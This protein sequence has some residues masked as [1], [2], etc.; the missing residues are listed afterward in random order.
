MTGDQPDRDALARSLE[1]RD[2]VAAQVALLRRAGAT[3]AEA[4][5][6]LMTALYDLSCDRLGDVEALE[7]MRRFTDEKELELM[8]AAR[9]PDGE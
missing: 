6:G 8:H 1:V 9:S 2:H 7:W 4:L 5:A 3:E